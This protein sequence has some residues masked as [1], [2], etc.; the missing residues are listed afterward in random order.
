MYFT[1]NSWRYSHPLD[2]YLLAQ[3]SKKTISQITKSTDDV[4]RGQQKQ[5]HSN[6]S[7]QLVG[8]RLLVINPGFIFQVAS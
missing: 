2:G 1:L 8:E 7:H 3:S 6:C 5:S 4:D